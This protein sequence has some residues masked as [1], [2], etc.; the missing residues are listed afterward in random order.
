MKN[1]IKKLIIVVSFFSAV[2]QVYAGTTVYI[3]VGGANEILII[4]GDQDKIVGRI[5]EVMNAHGLAATPDGK[6][7]VAGSMSLAPKD[8]IIPEGMTAEEHSAH[9]NSSNDQNSNANNGLSF[10][11]LIDTTTSRVLQ[12]IEVDGISHH[13]AITPDGRYAISTHTTA[14]GISIIDLNNRSLLKKIST[15]PVPNY[16]LI[17]GD[18]EYVYVSNSG[19]NTISE[20]ETSQWILRRNFSAGM[21]PEHMV[22]SPDE[23]TIYVNNVGDNTVAA[24]PLADGK[25]SKVYQVGRGPHGID[26]SDNGSTL[27]VSSKIGNKLTSINIASG[28]M[29]D[30]NL[31]PMPY[32]IKSIKGTGKLY[33]SSRAKPWIW[34]LN[35]ESL[36]VLRKIP[37][38]GE[39]HQ[40][41]MVQ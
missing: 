15:G 23:Q 26:L 32:H 9:H 19:N 28:I 36:Q 34:V 40:I 37:I 18:G 10:V 27:F 12:R 6:Y 16:V 24:I 7:L 3:P 38:N 22:F 11:S 41:V 13:S 20:I 14:G 2:G 4:D 5:G 30:I 17:S 1:L 8:Q 29:T 33:V 31:E 21:T 39:G 25:V 35:Q